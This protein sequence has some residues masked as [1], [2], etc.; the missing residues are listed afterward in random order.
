MSVVTQTLSPPHQPRHAARGAGTPRHWSRL[1]WQLAGHLYP[2][3][4]ARALEREWFRPPRGT[5]PDHA[6][7]ELLAQA[8]MDWAL[9]TGQGASR[10]VR[11]YRWGSSGPAVLLAHGWGGH[12]AQ[13][14]PLVA[15]LLAAG[16]RV[17]AFDALSHGASDAGARGAD[18]TSV[19]EMSRAL[20]A[21]AWHAGPIHAVVSHSLGSAALALAIREGLHLQA[22]VMIAPPADMHRAAAA[23]AWRLGIGPAIL[24][25][26]QRSS[27]RWL[28]M[29]W[30]ALNVPALGRI[31]PV[32]PT[33]VVH[34]RQDHEV[35]WENG[36]AIVGAWPGAK[37]MTTEGLGHRRVLRDAGVI[38]STVDFLGSM[39]ALP[40]H[41]R[42]S[43]VAALHA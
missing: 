3:G 40:R 21:T 2:P 23:L 43:G 37:L 35:C 18:Q 26:M 36:A 31:R 11:V 5:G 14:Q 32:P 24:A 42:T 12:A 27:E 9:V 22:A 19:V 41:A 8:R 38:A 25:R 4:A 10:R 29:P 28:G 13:W 7:R 6:G 16:M 33:L 15:P 30:S 1:L 39:A 17:V 20:L 34:D